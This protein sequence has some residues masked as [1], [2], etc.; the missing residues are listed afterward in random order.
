MALD[1]TP[2]N[3]QLDA[4]PSVHSAAAGRMRLHR[5]RRRMGLRCIVVELR[6]TE[7]DELVRR[8]LLTEDTRNDPLALRQALQYRRQCIPFGLGGRGL[9]TPRS[10]PRRRIK[11]LLRV[12]MRA[13]G[14]AA[15]CSTRPLL[16]MS[17]LLW[18]ELCATPQNTQLDAEPSVHSAAAGNN[19]NAK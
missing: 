3:T 15:V 9:A 13:R 14:A 6:E 16:A 8:G 10:P 7:V 19:A 11:T 17:A 5:Q 2:Q 4:E 12:R 1:A 18:P